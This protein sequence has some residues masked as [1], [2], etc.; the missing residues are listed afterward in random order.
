VITAG[1]LTHA[2]NALRAKLDLVPQPKELTQVEIAAKLE[3]KMRRDFANSI[4]PQRLE[5]QKRNQQKPDA[6]KKATI[7]KNSQPSC[8]KSNTKLTIT[9]AAAPAGV[10][11]F[12]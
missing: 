11:D 12:S 3:A 6:E 4:A 5:V 2:Y 10:L 7:K 8:P 9:R 1:G